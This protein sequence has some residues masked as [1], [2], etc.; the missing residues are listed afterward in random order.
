MSSTRT[1]L[2]LLAAA[3]FTAGCASGTVSSGERSPGAIFVGREVRP[4][5]EGPGVIA[6]SDLAEVVP[7]IAELRT[8]PAE[9]ALVV[10]QSFAFDSLRVHAYDASGRQLGVL[11]VFDREMQPGAAVLTIFGGVRAERP[12]ESILTVSPPQ[13]RRYGG[14]RPSPT[15]QVRVR[16]S[17]RSLPAA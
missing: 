7:L 1:L 3:A 9:L 17:A 14:G 6:R 2:I 13:W 4:G 16:V 5:S 12:G 10:G 15:T 11:P 8:E